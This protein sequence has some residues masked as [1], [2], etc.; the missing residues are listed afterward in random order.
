MADEKPA[1]SKD[2]LESMQTWLNGWGPP[3]TPNWSD[4]KG[5][6]IPMVKT[7]LQRLLNTVESWKKRA[8]QHGCNVEEGDHEC[9]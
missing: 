6:T 1:L 7:Q 9:G 3:G 4:E 8:A 2:E 5:Q